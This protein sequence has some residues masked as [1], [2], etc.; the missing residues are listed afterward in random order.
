VQY[1]GGTGVDVIVFGADSVVNGRTNI[2]LGHGINTFVDTATSAYAGDLNISGG[3]G[4][5]T[6]V[7]SGILNGNFINTLGNGD[8]NTTVFTGTL[9]GIVRYRLGNGSLGTF[10]LAPSV[11][12][13]VYVDAIF[14]S[15]D[16]T[17]NLGP[18]VTMGGIVRGTGG[19]YTFNQGTA[20]LGP[21]LQFIN[22]P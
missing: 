11:A 10:T 15:G 14:G 17:F 12:T 6:V 19:V 21:T 22:Y 7:V 4:T 18:N 5:N 9:G 3:D 8:G 1:I 2:T 16:S 13:F 20:V